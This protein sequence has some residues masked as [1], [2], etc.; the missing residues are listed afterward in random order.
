VK[1]KKE[2]RQQRSF[3]SNFCNSLAGYALH[4]PTTNKEI[5]D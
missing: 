4:N 2:D 3:K 5:E 1:K